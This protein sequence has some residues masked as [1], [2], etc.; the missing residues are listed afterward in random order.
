MPSRWIQGILALTLVV[1]LFSV[2]GATQACCGEAPNYFFTVSVVGQPQCDYRR[3]M[4]RVTWNAEYHLPSNNTF[5]HSYGDGV[6]QGT[7]FYNDLPHTPGSSVD[8]FSSSTVWTW[9]PLHQ[10]SGSYR[11]RVEF[12]VSMPVISQYTWA[13][14]V[15]D[16]TS[17]GVQNLTVHNGELTP[18]P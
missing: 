18:D 2:S 5:V 15:F 8:T 17:R 6:T 9:S 11:V 12:Y 13:L 14:I 4:G 3:Q 1:I 16:C 7:D 10:Q